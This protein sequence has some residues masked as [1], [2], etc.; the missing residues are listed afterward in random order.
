M[1]LAYKTTFPISEAKKTDIVNLAD[2]GHIPEEVV[3]WYKN[4]PSSKKSTQTEHLPEPNF[5]EEYPENE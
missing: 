4:L 3:L 2:A 5:D 1:K